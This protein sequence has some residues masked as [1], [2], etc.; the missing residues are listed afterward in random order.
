MKK[1]KGKKAAAAKGGSGNMAAPKSNAGKW[2][3]AGLAGITVA[4]LGY[5]G[6]KYLKGRQSAAAAAADA[7]PAFNWPVTPPPVPNPVIPPLNVYK[8]E[9]KPRPQNRPAPEQTATDSFPLKR[10]S[11]G[12]NVEAFQQAL[13]N[14][15]GKEI[16]PRYG[17]DGQF[18][19]EMANALKKLKLPARVDLT[20]FNIIVK[21]GGNPQGNQ[22]AAEGSI[23]KNLADAA[24]KKDFAAAIKALRQISGT[25]GYTAVNT[26]FKNMRIN[27]GVRQ[28]LVNGMLNAFADEKQKREIRLEFQRM[29]LIYDG[30]KWSLSGLDGLTIVTIDTA[31]VWADATKSVQVPQRTVLGT[32]IA[33]RL[34][35]TLFENKGKHFLVQTSKVTYL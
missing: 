26:L 14:T 10:G 29:G 28:T 3:W 5:F 21:G 12:G 31:T 2:M 18:G 34:D 7:L 16:L 33:R 25:D 19:T 22:N 13:I 24:G 20:T 8:P 9:P 17:A 35:Y 27:G 11:R 4:G 1:Q 30:S 23:A 32:E 6:W 15:Y